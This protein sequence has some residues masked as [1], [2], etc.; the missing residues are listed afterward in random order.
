MERASQVRPP[1]FGSIFARA[2]FS[3][4]ASLPL[5]LYVLFFPGVLSAPGGNS[6]VVAF[7][8]LLFGLYWGAAD[9]FFGKVW[10]VI[11]VAFFVWPIFSGTIIIFAVISAYQ[12]AS[13][14]GR[15][16]I[17]ALFA[18]SL[19]IPFRTSYT[20]GSL[21]QVLPFWHRYQAVTY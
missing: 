5:Y 18:A 20:I 21:Y 1:P 3:L 19:F 15:L 7:W 9:L 16:L 12:R 2:V 8:D 6:Y 14:V 10:S 13:K 11:G 4:F 17:I